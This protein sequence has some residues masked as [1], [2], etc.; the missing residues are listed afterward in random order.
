MDR[1]SARERKI[2]QK[3]LLLHSSLDRNLGLSRHRLETIYKTLVKSSLLYCCSLWA[4]ITRTK[5]GC[6]KLR[7]VERQYNVLTTRAFKTVHTG[8]L[9]LLVGT[10]PADYRVLEI[11]MKRYFLS[12]LPSFSIRALEA[13]SKHTNGIDSQNQTP[14]QVKTAIKNRLSSV[15]STEWKNGSQ[16][17]ATRE[18]F[19]TPKCFQRLRTSN[20][21]HQVVQVIT[22]HSFLN[23]HQKRF[24]F[25]PSSRCKCSYEQETRHHFLF[26]CPLFESFRTSFRETSFQLTKT[27]PPS[28]QEIHKHQALFIEL[29]KFVL[30]TKRLDS[31][32]NSQWAENPPTLSTLAR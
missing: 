31:R 11:T 32:T 22:G 1:S 6:K 7:A 16:G 29:I 20:L 5:K 30:K 2:S 19:P 10:L 15:W 9:S 8:A 26:V 24:N 18:F 28:I 21:P 14:S 12:N 4:S 25:I 17:Q 23:H 13:I 3:G 27:W